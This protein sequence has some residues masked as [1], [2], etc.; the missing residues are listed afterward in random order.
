MIGTVGASSKLKPVEEFELRQFREAGV[1][2]S[3]CASYFH[4]SMAT[5]NHVLA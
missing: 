5:V 1:S 4:V 2:I 3:G